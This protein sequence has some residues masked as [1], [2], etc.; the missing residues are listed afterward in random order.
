MSLKTCGKSPVSAESLICSS[1]S[2][3]VIFLIIFFVLLVYFRN[4]S[5]DK[6]LIFD[7][8]ITI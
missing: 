2:C 1:E 4:R 5:R 7:Y 8:S 6:K 3:A